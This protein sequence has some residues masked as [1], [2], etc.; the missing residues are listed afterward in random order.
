[1]DL[2]RFYEAHKA[3]YASA[4]EEIK[5]GHKQTHWIW[6]IFPQLAGLG[7]STMAQYYGIR[8]LEEAKAYVQDP[9][10]G[11][12]LIEISNALLTLDTSNPTQVM[13]YPDDMKLRSCMTLFMIAAPEEP[14]FKKVLDK[15]YGGEADG[16]TLNMLGM[17]EG[18]K[19]E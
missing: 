7:F 19:L 1:M 2:T 15:Y 12:D 9:V 3:D 16:N 13:G 18:K 14:V 17:T 8:D 11:R 4:L 5:G 10:L 6:Y